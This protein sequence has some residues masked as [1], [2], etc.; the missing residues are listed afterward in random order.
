MADSKEN[1]NPF[2]KDAEKEEKIERDEDLRFYVIDRYRNWITKEYID[3]YLHLFKCFRTFDEALDYKKRAFFDDSDY[4]VFY[5][6]VDNQFLRVVG[7][8]K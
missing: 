4:G 3:E 1:R 2:C 8:L 7:C 5:R 6:T